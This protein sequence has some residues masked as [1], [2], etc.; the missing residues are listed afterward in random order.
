VSVLEL[1]DVVVDYRRK[2]LPDVRAVAGV[3]MNVERGQI[4]GL[5]GESGCGKSTLGRAASGLLAPTGG[6]VLFEGQPVTPLGRGPRPLR[7]RRIQMVF[8]DPNSSLNGRRKIGDQVADGL[9][10]AQQMPA[11]QRRSRVGE[12]LELVG[13][14]AKVAG[15]FPHEF[16]GGQRQRICIA[17]A[18][19][20][21]PSV[22]I[23]DEPISALDASAQAQIANLLRELATELDVGLLFIS[24]DLA[25]VRHIADVV[26]V[27][28]L[29]KVAEFGSTAEVW[30]APLHPYSEA[31]I[32]AVLRADG[33]GQMPDALPGDVPDPAD[34]PPGCR[35]QTRCPAVMDRCR[36]E[37]PTLA[38]IRVPAPVLGQEGVDPA[39]RVACWL[40]EGH[41]VDSGLRAE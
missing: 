10:L 6:Q 24:H 7:E 15:R 17:R 2:H 38:A 34:P 5:V 14:E 3:S 4:V 40:H 26:T 20:A 36:I 27:M 25:I 31:L 28:Y 21:D 13:L 16:S 12:L 8:Q 41:E 1:R 18:L 39:H 30:D 37:E 19:S 29:G 11:E 9:E 35:F 23:A 32:G 22:I 33:V